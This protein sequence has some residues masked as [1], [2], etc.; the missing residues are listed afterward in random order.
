[1]FVY[2]CGMA[3]YTWIVTRDRFVGDS[4]D[5]VGKIG[6]SGAKDRAPFDEVIVNGEKFRLLNHSGESEFHG[7]IYGQYYGPEPLDEYGRR[8][9]CTDIEYERNGFWISLDGT[10]H[11]Q[12]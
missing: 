10:R 4:S 11:P 9:G 3:K 2:I 1:M 6:P 12:I 7:Y 5:A 8:Y